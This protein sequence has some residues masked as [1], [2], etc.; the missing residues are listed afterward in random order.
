MSHADF[1]FQAFI[2]NENLKFMF[3]ILYI[4][5]FFILLITLVLLV[6]LFPNKLKF[7]LFQTHKN[8]LAGRR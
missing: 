5:V 7:A 3:F 8:V 1:I 6:S 4:N 2:C